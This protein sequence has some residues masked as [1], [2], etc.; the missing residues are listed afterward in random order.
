MTVRKRLQRRA[1]IPCP[2]ILR[3]LR[4]GRGSAPER[5]K[6]EE[7]SQRESEKARGEEK[8]GSKRERSQPARSN[9]GA[10]TSL[11]RSSVGALVL[12][13]HSSP[14]AW[15]GLAAAVWNVFFLLLLVKD[16]PLPEPKGLRFVSGGN[17]VEVL[18]AGTGAEPSHLE[19][20]TRRRGPK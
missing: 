7:G 18:V 15:T 8:G 17:G 5:I 9:K 14:K 16:H 19:D 13:E 10:P 6:G 11:E 3:G 1:T 20:R 2:E 12:W 4:R